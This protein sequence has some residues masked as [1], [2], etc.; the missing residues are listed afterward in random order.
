MGC[1]DRCL[2]VQVDGNFNYALL[3][4]VKSMCPPD[5]DG[6][7]HRNKLTEVLALILRKE[8]QR[9]TAREYASTITSSAAPPG[10][11]ERCPAQV[12]VSS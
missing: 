5:D 3:K 11:V 4:Q 9:V 7:W 12:K 2:V 6:S 1:A 8:H 10:E